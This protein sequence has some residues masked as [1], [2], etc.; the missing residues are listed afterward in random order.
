MATINNDKEAQDKKS[1]NKWN[2]TIAN[3]IE[4]TVI[5]T[6]DEMVI[7]ISSTIKV[8]IGDGS[9]INPIECVSDLQDIVEHFKVAVKEKKAPEIT[10]SDCDSDYDFDDDLWDHCYGSHKYDNTVYLQWM[11]EKEKE[12]EARMYIQP[13]VEEDVV[14]AARRTA[15]VATAAA[16]AAYGAAKRTAFAKPAATA[17]E[18]TKAVG[19][20]EAAWR[21]ALQSSTAVTAEVA[22]AVEAAWS[23][24]GVTAKSAKWGRRARTWRTLANEEAK[25]TSKATAV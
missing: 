21:E 14:V 19:V 15:D 3:L 22:E 25:A 7:Y 16:A 9:I 5:R 1:H 4:E 24:A 11:I 23:V 8:H 18:A 6:V 12:F 13:E 10:D 2:K 20:L 17:A